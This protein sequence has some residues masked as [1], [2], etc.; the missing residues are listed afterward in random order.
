M[1][2]SLSCQTW[3]YLSKTSST[4]SQN[5]RKPV[6][7]TSYRCK[8]DAKIAS[9]SDDSDDE[10]FTWKKKRYGIAS[11]DQQSSMEY[12]FSNSINKNYTFQ[13]HNTQFS[14]GQDVTDSNTSSKPKKNKNIWGSVLQSQMLSQGFHGFDM[15]HKGDSYSDRQVESYSYKKA[16]KDTRPWPVKPDIDSVTTSKKNDDLFDSVPDLE[17]LEENFNG[18]YRKAEKRRRSAKK[19][20]GPKPNDKKSCRKAFDV[21]ADDDDD[22]KIT[23]AIANFLE[24]SKVYLIEKVVQVLGKKKAL[25]VARLTRDVEEHGGMMTNDGGRRRTPGGV[26]FQLLKTDSEVTKQNMK[27]IFNDEKKEKAKTKKILRAKRFKNKLKKRMEADM[28]STENVT[29]ETVSGEQ[30]EDRLAAVV[31]DDTSSNSKDSYSQSNSSELSNDPV[32][33]DMSDLLKRHKE[34]QSEQQTMTDCSEEKTDKD[35]TTQDQLSMSSKKNDRRPDAVIYL[36]ED[37]D[38]SFD[39]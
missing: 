7:P 2:V 4:I 8:S 22:E 14:F 11:K 35:S 29:M 21:T 26:F 10:K 19:R 33:M 20:L 5:Y 9:S 17:K 15:E 13:V 32:N 34:Y 25:D 39:L 24:E 23:E 38:M 6:N 30:K 12:S 18:V 28:G 27:D 31:S 1:N 3:F 16:L 37:I 36:D